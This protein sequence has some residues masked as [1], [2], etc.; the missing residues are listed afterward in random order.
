M[1]CKGNSLSIDQTQRY[2]TVLRRRVVLANKQY[3]EVRIMNFLTAV[4][5]VVG[6]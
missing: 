3:Y 1:P 6:F 2:G 4:S 5:R